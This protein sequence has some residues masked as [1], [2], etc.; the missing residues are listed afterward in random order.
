MIKINHVGILAI[1]LLFCSVAKIYNSM[2][3]AMEVKPYRYTDLSIYRVKLIRC[4]DEYYSIDQLAI[5]MSKL[6]K[7]NFHMLFLMWC[8]TLQS[9]MPSYYF[10]ST[11]TSERTT[12][13]GT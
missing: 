11:Q 1:S 5:T 9:I 12:G 10:H 7:S 8:T 2:G 3:E 13:E 4:Y 6:K